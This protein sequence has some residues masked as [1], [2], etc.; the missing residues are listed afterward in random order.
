[1][2]IIALAAALAFNPRSFPRPANSHNSVLS[3]EEGK[4]ILESWVLV[5]QD[6]G[7]NGIA[8]FDL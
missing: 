2:L 1:M 8:F 3:P 5:E 7:G 4:D 6:L